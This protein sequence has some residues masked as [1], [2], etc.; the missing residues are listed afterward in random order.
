MKIKI[1][2]FIYLL[3]FWRTEIMAQ[4]PKGNTIWCRVEI[5]IV[6]PKEDKEKIRIALK[7]DSISVNRRLAEI[8]KIFIEVLNNSKYVTVVDATLKENQ[9]H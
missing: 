4:V 1:I 3:C 8:R 5:F 9:E 2:L 6:E 7:K